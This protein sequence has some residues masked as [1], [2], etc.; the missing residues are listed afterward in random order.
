MAR[1][2]KYTADEVI[3]AIEEAKGI[4]AEAARILGCTR[5]TVHNYVNRYPTVRTVYEDET[6]K[7]V[8]FAEGKLMDL[9]RAKNVSAIIFFLK[10]KAKH[11]GYVERQEIAHDGK[12]QIEFVNDWRKVKDE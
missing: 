8:D 11:R 1:N 9:I 3:K 7:S 5:R 10:T 2:N 12:I 6:E 4:L